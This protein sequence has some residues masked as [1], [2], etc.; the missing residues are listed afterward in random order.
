MEN[1][2]TMTDSPRGNP[3]NQ[4]I[5]GNC[6]E[7]LDSLPEQSVDLV[8]GSPPYENA[9]SYGIDFNLSGQDWVDWMLTVYQKSLRVCKGLVAF[10][11][12]GR[13]K[14]YQWSCTPALLI[15]DLHRKGIC[16]RE[17]PY[18]H[19][20]GIP[21]SGGPDWLRH[22][23]EFIISATNGGKL[24][25]SD[26]TA[27]GTPPK[28]KPGGGMTHRLQNGKRVRNIN[29]PTIYFG[30]DRGDSERQQ[31]YIPP[32]I[33]NPG[34]IVF[35]KGGH[36]GSK[37][38]HE[39]EAPFPETL[40]EFMIRSFCPPDGTVLDPFSGSG[41]TACVAKRWGRN[42]I[43]I[44]IRQSQVDLTLRRLQEETNNNTLLQD[45]FGPRNDETG[46]F[47]FNVDAD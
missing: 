18:Y 17:G 4:V 11:V 37:L 47:D 21:G 41:T 7:V 12:A 44:D 36:L 5:C 43:A 25:W 2:D 1:G 46:L 3:L 15:A 13:T 10:V 27:T 45:I 24:P 32:D 38:A 40:A 6:L 30:K 20:V 9:R 31:L 26:N 28:Y 33:T 22:D 16:V 8:F 29:A 23:I 42:Y 14:N 34:N 35:C 19:R 39:N